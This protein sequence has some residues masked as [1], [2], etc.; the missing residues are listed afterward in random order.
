MLLR[1]A[2]YHQVYH[3]STVYVTLCDARK[4]FDTVDYDSLFYK[5]YKMGC[6]NVLWRIL[7]SFYT[8]FR[9]CVFIGGQQ[10][11][12]FDVLL[13]VHQGAPLSMLMYMT[14]NNDLLDL[15]C[16]LNL[17]AR[18]AG[19][20]F[21]IVCP[22]YADDVAVIA[23]H[24][25]MVQD[26]IQKI[27]EHSAKWR[28]SVNPSKSHVLIF[29]KDQC[30]NRELFL[31]LHPI[32]TI[33]RDNHLRVPL[34][35]SDVELDAAISERIHA[36][37]SRFFCSLSIGTRFHRLP[38]N[39]L[40]RL[41]W[42]IV[43]PHMTYGLETVAMSAKSIRQ[44][45]NAHISMAKIIQGLPSQAACV[46]SLPAL[47]WWSMK[48][49]LMYRR[50]IFMWQI[51]SLPTESVYKSLLLFIFGW[52][53]NKGRFNVDSYKS[54][55]GMMFFACV[56]IGVI[57]YVNQSINQGTYVSMTVW[58]T[59]IR[60]IL[61]QR[62]QRTRTMHSLIYRSS[63][64]FN[65][66]IN[67]GTMWPWWQFCN[68]NPSLT[69]QC[70]VILRLITGNN[71]ISE[72]WRK[73]GASRCCQ[74]CDAMC[75]DSIHHMLFECSATVTMNRLLW[76]KVLEEAPGALSKERTNMNSADRTIFILSGLRGYIIE[77]NSVFINLCSF[78]STT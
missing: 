55:M 27:F 57:D 67:V 7:R 33:S 38:P 23:L 25:P 61:W 31:G 2:V 32:G 65:K 18:V 5:L 66:C 58:K 48:H 15:L 12:W 1:E 70:V 53:N 56:Q 10:S 21:P 28:Y 19:F 41:Y 71:V 43:I 26:I 51:L 59:K 3:G 75:S 4:A 30:P 78:I 72:H 20:E 68:Y 74:I 42:S 9:S 45:E 63:L 50:L 49:Y 35:T 37:R 46:V 34:A 69:P 60:A 44:L 40:S 13:G 36:G 14:F 76:Q 6:N 62:E 52:L 64:Y 29:R 16:T 54:P 24:K 8:D 11:S 22:A 17:G 47:G 73:P 77:W 39:V